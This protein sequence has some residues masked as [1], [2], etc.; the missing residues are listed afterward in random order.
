MAKHLDKFTSPFFRKAASPSC[1]R[2]HSPTGRGQM[3]DLVCR[4]SPTRQP[5]EC[6]ADPPR[7]EKRTAAAAVS[8]T[9]AG[10]AA[11]F[12]AGG[13]FRLLR[14][15][16]YHSAGQALRIT[17]YQPMYGMA[18]CFLDAVGK[19][20]PLPPADQIP[21]A[22][23]MLE[24][25]RSG[26]RCLSCNERLC[27]L[28]GWSHRELLDRFGPERP[29][30]SPGLDGT[31]A[32][33]AGRS[34][35]QSAALPRVPPD[36][37]GE[38]APVGRPAGPAT[39]YPGGRHRLYA[40]VLDIDRQ[41]RAEGQLSRPSPGS[42]PPGGRPF[43]NL[44]VGCCLLR[45]SGN[46]ALATLRVSRELARMLTPTR[47]LCSIRCAPPSGTAACSGAGRAFR[48]GSSGSHCKGQPLR[49]VCR[50]VPVRRQSL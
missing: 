34:S 21:A 1:W 13:V 25:S 44:P 30:G 15:L 7:C 47:R 19:R 38:D 5:E 17:C 4:F 29:C 27:A 16:L 28:T 42:A 41:R 9:V 32:I 37:S 36:L 24:L 2:N 46:G 14:L 48:R 6:R 49:H 20:R 45:R 40:V 8:H 3:V 23:A 31:A 26:V 12:A 10:P 43:D 35:G 50:I 22:A 11:A 18:A 39:A 33:P